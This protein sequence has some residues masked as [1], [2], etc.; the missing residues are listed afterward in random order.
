MIMIDFIH[1]LLI[2]FY[3]FLKYFISSHLLHS[4]TI[5]HSN[6]I[7]FIFHSLFFLNIHF[8]VFHYSSCSSSSS[9]LQDFRLQKSLSIY[10]HRCT[11]NI[12]FLCRGWWMFSAFSWRV[13]LVLIQK[14]QTCRSIPCLQSP[15]PLRLA[16][17]RDI[18]NWSTQRS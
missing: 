1:F 2:S 8:I 13:F 5:I 7:H 15:G 17:E 6:S 14:Q 10:T 16:L 11:H 3:F 9:T 4:S 12:V 18:Q